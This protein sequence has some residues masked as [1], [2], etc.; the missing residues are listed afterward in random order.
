MASEMLF[1]CPEEEDEEAQLPARMP[2]TLMRAI[3]VIEAL[4]KNQVG[5]TS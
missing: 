3:A 4:C 2:W 1:V 5:R